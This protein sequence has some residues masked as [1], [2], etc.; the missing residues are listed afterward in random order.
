MDGHRCQYRRD[1]HGWSALMAD[2]G[3]PVL[4]LLGTLVIT[5]NLVFL[6]DGRI[7]PVGAG[8]FSTT[9][10]HRKVFS[11]LTQPAMTSILSLA[12]VLHRLAGGSWLTLAGWRMAFTVLEVNGASL[13][14]LGRMIQYRCPPFW[15]HKTIAADRG[16]IFLPT[17]WI[18][19]L[20]ATPS[21]FTSPLLTGAVNWIPTELY[22]KSD[23][24]VDIPEPGP[25]R[26]WNEHNDWDN[27]RVYEVYSA[28]GLASM[29]TS[30]D[31]YLNETATYK[32]ALP[33]LPSIPSGSTLANVTIPVF[34]INQLQPVR[35][36]HELSLDFNTVQSVIDDSRNPNQNFSKSGNLFG[37][38]TDVGR[39]AI[40]HTKPWRASARIENPPPGVQENIYKYPAPTVVDEKTVVI[41]GMTYLDPCSPND[42]A[43]FGSFLDFFTFEYDQSCY[44]FFN[45]DY[46]AGVTTC[47]DC[48]V[49]SNGITSG[50]MVQVNET[51]VDIQPHPLV[52]TALAMVPDVLFYTQIA[53]SSFAPTFNNIEGYA[54]GT[55]STAYQASWNS[56]A[57]R[58]ASDSVAQTTYHR[59]VPALLAHLSKERVTAWCALNILFAISAVLL[60]VVRRRCESKAIVSPWLSA[61]FLDT[62][63]VIS[64]DTTGFCNARKADEQDEKMRLRL[65][66][67]D[68]GAGTDAYKHPVLVEEAMSRKRDYSPL[69]DHELMEWR[70]FPGGRV[71]NKGTNTY[72]E[73]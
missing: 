14:E 65:R 69:A 37:D 10:S 50:G 36:K 41:I 56:L 51:T 22:E 40:V 28:I 58:F 34:R 27:N 52:E 35:E 63:A 3:L 31:F 24:V 32:R 60:Y 43:T 68:D 8:G 15:T 19:T 12:L 46:T 48:K 54:R 11:L 55:L 4:H 29:A 45:L 25:S 39:I 2:W 61:I 53:N 17:L 13:S 72:T 67:R 71:E 1:D 47:E 20:L 70:G 30:M 42:S 16:T 66:C 33:W 26:G 18:I 38:G 59:P 64:N 5:L 6:V 73:E 62:S 44:V 21:L 9:E 49:Q 7:F 23:N 57:R